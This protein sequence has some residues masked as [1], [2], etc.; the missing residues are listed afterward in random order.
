[1]PTRM[2]D[3]SA[4]YLMDVPAL[5]AWSDATG[6]EFQIVLGA[7]KSGA[8]VVFNRVWDGLKEAYPDEAAKLK[9]NQ[10]PRERFTPEQRLAAAAIADKLEATFPIMS[11]GYDDAVEWAVAGIAVTGPYTIVTDERRKQK[12]AQIDGVAVITYDELLDEL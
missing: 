12:Y 8:V 11:A 3:T 10:F 9:T 6:N 5:K 4:P 7:A 1:M 2:P